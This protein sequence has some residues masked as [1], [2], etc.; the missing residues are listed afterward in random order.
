[1]K[2]ILLNISAVILGLVIGG[3]VNMSIINISG[4]IIPPPNGIDITTEEGLKAAMEFFEPKHFLFPFL[5]HAIGT[6]VGAFITALIA[7]TYRKTLALVIG[8]AYLI[9]GIM[10]INLVPSPLWFSITDLVLAY[11][12]I[13]FLGYKIAIKLKK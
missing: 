8:L 4:S 2:T 7:K 13:A 1:M 3:F 11:I 5:A 9:G 12:P 6:L 10:M